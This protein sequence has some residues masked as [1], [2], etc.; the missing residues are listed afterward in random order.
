M[1]AGD[2]GDCRTGGCN[3]GEAC[4]ECLGPDG[5]PIFACIMDGTSC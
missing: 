4:S 2:A 5:D 1:D 3:P